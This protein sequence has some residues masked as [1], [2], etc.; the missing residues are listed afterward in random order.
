MRV[1]LPLSHASV[2]SRPPLEIPMKSQKT[3]K[4]PA[5]HLAPGDTVIRRSVAHLIVD[6]TPRP[7]GLLRLSVLTDRIT[8]QTF[9]L[10]PTT[11]VRVIANPSTL[12]D[13]EPEPESY[14]PAVAELAAAKA[15]GADS[16]CFECSG[17]GIYYGHGV[18][19]NGVFKGYT[20][21]C[22]RCEGKGHQT[23][24][25]RHRNDFYD[26]HYRRIE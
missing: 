12:L 26:N 10:D 2:L 8:P 11:E 17:K 25:D 9:K 5:S 7:D 22:Y 18:V 6:I 14:D 3:L 13:P 20:G 16:T 1:L 23:A 21:P 4:I 24:A 19:E 15:T